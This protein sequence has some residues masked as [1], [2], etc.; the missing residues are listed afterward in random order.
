MG[1][2]VKMTKP[3]LRALAQR[4]ACVRVFLESEVDNRGAAGS[5]MSDYQKEAQDALDD[6]DSVIAALKP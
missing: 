5:D 2:I 6:L 4:L 3:Q 1:I